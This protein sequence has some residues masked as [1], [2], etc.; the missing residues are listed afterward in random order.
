VS[1]K[2]LTLTAVGGFWQGNRAQIVLQ[3]MAT[4]SIIDRRKIFELFT[5]MIVGKRDYG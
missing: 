2:V 4:S 3:R 1:L 5:A